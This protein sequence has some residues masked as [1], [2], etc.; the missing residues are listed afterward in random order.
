[1]AVA[2]KGIG[3]QT[4][5]DDNS[6]TAKV[7]NFSSNVEG[8]FL[9]ACCGASNGSTN[10]NPA[11]IWNAETGWTLL[12]LNVWA[13]ATAGNTQFFYRFAPAGGITN[14]TFDTAGTTGSVTVGLVFTGVD[15]TTP[16][17]VGPNMQQHTS[18]TVTNRSP[19]DYTTTVND[20]MGIVSMNRDAAP[21]TITFPSGYTDR[22]Q[23]GSSLPGDGIINCIGTLLHTSSGLQTPGDFTWTGAQEACSMSFALS[24]VLATHEQD[25]FRME[26]D[27]GTESGSTF[28]A[29][30]NT[31][32]TRNRADPFRVRQGGQ[33]V[34]DPAAL[35]ATLQYKESS[36]GA[37]EWRDVP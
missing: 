19:P 21:V 37:A 12:T 23:S 18:G 20:C 13:S 8:D 26:D 29:A 7:C 28:L 31:N 24:P 9:L 6:G 4:V 32:I 25:G 27:D 3:T 30:Q 34:G 1:M 33:L 22:I 14:Q 36:D 17:N 11:E 10:K 5:T 2:F 15:T 16:I 35:A